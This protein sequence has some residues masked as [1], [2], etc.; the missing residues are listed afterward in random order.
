MS[1]QTYKRLEKSVTWIGAALLTLFVAGILS[2][3]V[4]G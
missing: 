1:E 3:I 4:F 2:G